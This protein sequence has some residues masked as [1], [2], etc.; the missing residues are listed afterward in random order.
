[1]SAAGGSYGPVQRAETLWAIADRLRPD[2]VTV[3]QMMIAIYQANPA[4]FGSNINVLRAGVTLRLPESADFASL[5]ATVANAEVRRQT[6]EWQNRTPGGQ[7]RLLPPAETEVARAPAPAPAAPAPR[8]AAPPPAADRAAA[9][10]AAAAAASAEENRRLLEIRNAE[11]QR[12]Q[13]A[14][15]AEAAKC[16]ASGTGVGSARRRSRA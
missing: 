9:D 14:A 12:V 2:G 1:M 13:Q 16:T 7:L 6:D 3:N 10:A 8:P 5:A 11:L 15:A 4:A